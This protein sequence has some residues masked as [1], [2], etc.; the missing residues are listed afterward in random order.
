FLT[1][2]HLLESTMRIFPAFLAALVFALTGV[3]H[4][5]QFKWIDQDGK[6]RYGDTPPP[7]VKA[8]PL[9]GSTA[10]A[11]PSAVAPGAD[12]AKEAKKGPLTPA[13]QEQEYRKRQAEARKEGE[14]A[15]AER[16]A[17]TERNEGC[18]RTREYLRTLESGQRITRS[19]PSGERYYLDE[20]Q[21]AS[22]IAKAEQSVQQACK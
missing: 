20:N 21:V 3:A 10:P 1:L 2:L 15:D 12:A 16:R 6:L 4:A 18:E 5:Q 19:N 8:T 11:A 17:K 14:K 7:G 22:E 13:E 9:R